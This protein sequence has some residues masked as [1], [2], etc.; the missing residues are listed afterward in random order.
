M[1]VTTEKDISKGIS[2]QPL[3]LALIHE[4]D[5]FKSEQGMSLLSTAVSMEQKESNK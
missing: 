1:Y 5:I 3:S 2:R 4:E